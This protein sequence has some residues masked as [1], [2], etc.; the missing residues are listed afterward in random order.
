MKLTTEYSKY[1]NILFKKLDTGK[2]LL[3]VINMKRRLEKLY[4]FI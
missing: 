3:F 2:P 1:K 4:L